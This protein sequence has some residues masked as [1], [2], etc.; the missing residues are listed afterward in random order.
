MLANVQS[1]YTVVRHQFILDK[2]LLKQ[3]AGT[4]DVHDL[5][6]VNSLLQ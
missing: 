5:E 6:A 4:I 1:E 2:L 3:A